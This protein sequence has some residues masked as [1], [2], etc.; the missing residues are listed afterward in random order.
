MVTFYLFV[1][2]ALR[3]LAGESNIEP[4]VLR[5]RCDEKLRRKPGRT[6]Y[7]RG[8]L[9]GDDTGALTVSRTGPQGS[10]ILTSMSQANCFIVLPADLE[11][12]DP[13]TMVPVIPF[14][15]FHL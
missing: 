6:E 2:P 13:G 10:G 12:A 5:A 14:S 4:R 11:S 1:Q 7:Q 9:A 8:I 3:R 15:E